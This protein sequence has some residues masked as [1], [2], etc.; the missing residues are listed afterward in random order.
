MNHAFS[1]SAFALLMTGCATT[2]TPEGRNIS[3][4]NSAGAALSSDCVRLA[5][6]VGNA[7]PGWGQQIG[8]DQAFAEA[9]NKA[10]AIP[11]ADTLVVSMAQM[12]FSGGEVSGIAFDCSNKRVQ[13]IQN[14]DPEPINRVMPEDVFQKAKKC[15][16]LNGVWITDQCVIDME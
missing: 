14:V 10:G 5:P 6:V 1:V 15:Q 9:R 7:K 16:A 2:L 11:D 12:Q 4:V 13:L 3:V 8:L